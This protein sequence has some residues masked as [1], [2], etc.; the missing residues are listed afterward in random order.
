MVPYKV[1]V[2]VG[3]ERQAPYTSNPLQTHY[4]HPLMLILTLS[5]SI[6]TGAASGPL[7]VCIIEDGMNS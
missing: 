5:L 2:V 6:F 4:S 7:G 3:M 1:V